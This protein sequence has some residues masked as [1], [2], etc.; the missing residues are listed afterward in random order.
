MYIL[1]QALL[2]YERH[3]IRG[4]ELSVP[5]SSHSETLSIDNQVNLFL[6]IYSDEQYMIT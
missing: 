3:H 2:D 1:I 5:I 6:L 4:G